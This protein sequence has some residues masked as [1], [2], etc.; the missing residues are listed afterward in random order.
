MRSKL[1]N[2]FIDTE[3]IDD[4]E[5]LAEQSPALMKALGSEL[6]NRMLGAKAKDEPK[7]DEP[8]EDETDEDGPY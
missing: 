5:S 8:D 3:G 7:Q 1:G 6:L 2:W 4:L